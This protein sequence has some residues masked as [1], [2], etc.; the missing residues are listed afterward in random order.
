MQVDEQG[1][2]RRSSHC[3]APNVN[4]GEVYTLTEVAQV[5]AHREAVHM[6]AEAAQVQTQVADGMSLRWP[7]EILYSSLA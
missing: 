2:P 5:R 6:Q 7:T 3:R 1:G 4:R